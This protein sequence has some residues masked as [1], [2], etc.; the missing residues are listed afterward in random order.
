MLEGGGK[1]AGVGLKKATAVMRQI[2]EPKVV[3]EVHDEAV[4]GRAAEF[5]RREKPAA[6]LGE[7]EVK[8]L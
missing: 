1:L 3:E 4:I 2:L 7:G 8:S 5:E 6:V